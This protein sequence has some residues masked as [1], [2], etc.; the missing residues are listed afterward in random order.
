MP[1]T[2]DL[3][4]ILRTRRNRRGPRMNSRVPVTIAWNRNGP[5]RFESGFTRVVNCY[6]CLL[7]SPAEIDRLI[8]RAE[9]FLSQGDVVTARLLLQRGAEARDPRA[10]LALGATYDPNMLKRMGTVGIRPEPSQAQ[11]WYERA[12]EYGS[13]EASQRLTELAQLLR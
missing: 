9:T 8:S 3:P 12:S 1:F 7:V 13:R 2:E 10:A 4:R 11:K 5:L 6:G